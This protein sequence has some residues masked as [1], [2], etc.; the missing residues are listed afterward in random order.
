MELKYMG[1]MNILGGYFYEYKLDDNCSIYLEAWKTDK[2]AEVKFIV[3]LPGWTP[4]MTKEE[5][6]AYGLGIAG[7]I[8]AI[9]GRHPTEVFLEFYK[10]ETLFK[11]FYTVEGAIVKKMLYHEKLY[12]F[13]EDAYYEATTDC[14]RIDRKSVV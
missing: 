7:E 14:D 4:S 3:G 9:S 10:S 5:T 2:M 13:D 1:S 11:D 12:M 8:G 6:K